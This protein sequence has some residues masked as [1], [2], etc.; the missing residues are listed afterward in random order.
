MC[1]DQ[2]AAAS[3]VSACLGW[4]QV[5]NLVITN[6]ERYTWQGQTKVTWWLATFFQVLTESTEYGSITIRL[7][8]GNSKVIKNVSHGWDSFWLAL[9]GSGRLM[10]SS[11]THVI[12]NA[13]G[14][15][16]PWHTIGR[17]ELSGC[18]SPVP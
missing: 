1:G 11:Q 7:V 3:N 13:C 9:I 5:G 15:D 2:A 17:G 10:D 14:G 8:W 4:N 6:I 16:H 12:D 18:R